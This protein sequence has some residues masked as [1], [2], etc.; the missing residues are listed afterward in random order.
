MGKGDVERVGESDT[1][2]GGIGDILGPG[3]TPDDVFVYSEGDNLQ[4]IAA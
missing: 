3:L 2:Q 4:R 1:M